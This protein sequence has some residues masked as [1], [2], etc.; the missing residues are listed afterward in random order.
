MHFVV[1]NDL[2]SSKAALFL[3][4]ENPERRGGAMGY[5]MTPRVDTGTE[6]K[7]SDLQHRKQKC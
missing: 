6:M 1:G 7:L 4:E 2:F 5:T 3:Y